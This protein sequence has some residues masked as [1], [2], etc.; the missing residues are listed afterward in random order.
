MIALSRFLQFF[1]R[2]F[3]SLFIADSN[4][5]EYFFILK[6]FDFHKHPYRT[7]QRNKFF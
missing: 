3:V 5:A 6:M 2:P 4:K 7:D 1:Q